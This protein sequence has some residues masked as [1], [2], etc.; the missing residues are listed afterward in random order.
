MRE[1]LVVAGVLWGVGSA[2]GQITSI[3]YIGDSWFVDLNDQGDVFLAL[4]HNA[5][6]SRIWRYRD[7]V[8][9][10]AITGPVEWTSD[11]HAGEGGH[12]AWSGSGDAYR[13]SSELGIQELGYPHA[14][15][16]NVEAINRYGAVVGD[17]H[18]SWVGRIAWGAGRRRR[19]M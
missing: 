4:A 5:N 10:E 14:S 16:M 18:V 2:A 13:W 17:S 1:R 11:L 12:L 9:L 3:R 15:W 7:S 19:G 8:G 6:Q